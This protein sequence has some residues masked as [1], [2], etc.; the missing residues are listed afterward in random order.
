VGVENSALYPAKFLN[1]LNVSGLP[2]HCLAL[3]VACPIMLLRNMRGPP[4]MVNGP[5]LIVRA[6]S[7][8]IHDAEIVVGDFQG[9]RVFMPRNKMSP[10]DVVCPFKFAH[11]QF[12]VRPAFAVS[13]NKS[14][15]ETLER[16]AVYLPQPVFS[17]GHLYVALSRVGAPD[18]VSRNGPCLGRGHPR[19]PGPGVPSRCAPLSL[20]A[21]LAHQKCCICSVVVY[22]VALAMT[23]VS[24]SHRIL[25][26]SQHCSSAFVT[27]PLHLARPI[28]GAYI[29]FGHWIM[30]TAI[31]LEGVAVRRTG[32]GLGGD[33]PT[34]NMLRELGFYSYLLFCPAGIRLQGFSPGASP[35]G[36]CLRFHPHSVSFPWPCRSK[37]MQED[38]AIE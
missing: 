30:S 6:I 28:Y 38:A 36:I 15:G 8:V 29:T 9:T 1:T 24:G 34:G 18:R 33:L 7:G 17:H 3:K 35:A 11:L 13:I 16:I 10:S 5:R 14:Q 22:G 26:V 4:G 2:P 27:L 25:L 20:T 12:P 37:K 19:A 32:L 31:L 21:V 23:V